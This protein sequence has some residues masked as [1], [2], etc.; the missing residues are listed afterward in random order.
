MTPLGIEPVTLWLVA[1]CVNELR[2]RVL[3]CDACSFLKLLLT[4][5]SR[6]AQMRGLLD[7]PEKHVEGCTILNGT[8]VY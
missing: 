2:H 8:A 4:V 5:S 3:E 1:Q 6:A 7:W